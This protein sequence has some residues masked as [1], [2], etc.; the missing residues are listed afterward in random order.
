MRLIPFFECDIRNKPNF[1]L[2]SDIWTWDEENLEQKH[3]Y[4]Q[5]LFPDTTK[6]VFNPDAPIP[7]TEEIRLIGTD[8]LLREHYLRGLRVM[9]RFYGFV[10]VNGKM[11]PHARARLCF[12][13]IEHKSHN[14]LRITRIL[15]SLLL[16]GF[17]K[18][19]DVVLQGLTDYLPKSNIATQRAITD[20]WTP[21]TTS[22]RTRFEVHKL[23][24]PFLVV[25]QNVSLCSSS[26]PLCIIKNQ[27]LDQSMTLSDFKHMRCIRRLT[28]GNHKN[29]KEDF[30]IIGLE[31]PQAI[32]DA[33]LDNVLQTLRKSLDE[34]LV[35]VYA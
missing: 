30:D 20:Y 22:T 13:N 26:C 4:I 2:L 17:S 29:K 25:K 14:L 31:S 3:D 24:H 33:D 15:K 7:T 16:F 27:K 21:L 1:F 32:C 12:L 8:G 18:G 9:M 28:Q 11:V 10:F 35:F 6:S 5:W 19:F 23:G 34:F